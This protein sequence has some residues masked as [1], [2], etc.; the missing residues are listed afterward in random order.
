M[1][2][3][4]LDNATYRLGFG[5]SRAQSRQLVRHGH[6][7]VNSRKVNRRAARSPQLPSLLNWLAAGPFHPGWN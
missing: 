1:L 5:T 2:E 3:R 4:R 7:R 6:V